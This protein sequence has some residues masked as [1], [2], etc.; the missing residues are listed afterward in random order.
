MCTFINELPTRSKSAESTNK[1]GGK[2]RNVNY[3]IKFQPTTG[4]D[5]YRFRL[6]NFTSATCSRDFPFIE[7]YVHEHW[8]KVEGK[9]R[10]TKFITCPK[11]QYVQS[12]GTGYEC[13][14]CTYG[15]ANYRKWQESGKKDIISKKRWSSSMNKYVA[16]LPV[17]VVKD[18]NNPDNNGTLKTIILKDKEMYKH[19]LVLI[20]EAQK[21]DCV[22]NGNNAVDF[23]TTVVNKEIIYRE[24]EPT[25]YRFNRI[26][27][28]KMGFTTKPYD[29]PTITKE[30]VDSFPFDDEYYTHTSKEE[31]EEFLN[32]Y[33]MQP[34]IDIPDDDINFDDKKDA[35]EKVVVKKETKQKTQEVKAAINKKATQK[36]EEAVESSEDIDI[37]SLIEEDDAE[38]DS[39]QVDVTAD[40]APEEDFDLGSLDEL[41]EGIDK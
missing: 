16:I 10:L 21:S 26:Q 22:F 5:V 37:A 18:P 31:A 35:E 40:E 30:L 23:Y 11:T 14:I 20:K 39:S 38:G 34:D 7:K 4:K 19:L 1:G 41:L 13:P 8:E 25:E 9:D 17:Y 6:L 24:G 36:L 29:L 32:D 33:V 12:D 28:D 15:W 27:L 3:M 2:K